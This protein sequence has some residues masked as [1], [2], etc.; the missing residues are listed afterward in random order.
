MTALGAAHYA[1]EL[2]GSHGVRRP[3]ELEPADSR[4]SVPVVKISN[5]VG[6]N[7]GVAA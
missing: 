5:D 1:G 7:R 4:R 2:A 6:K 3:A